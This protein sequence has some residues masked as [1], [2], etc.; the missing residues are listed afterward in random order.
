[1]LGF[2][3]LPG[4]VQ[5]IAR[6]ELTGVIAALRWT[7][8]Y[9]V[10]TVLWC[11]SASTVERLQ[12]L[13][14]GEWQLVGVQA[15]NHDLWQLV[16]EL[17]AELPQDTFQVRWTPSHLD[18]ALCTTTWEEWLAEW[19]GVADSI[20][21]QTNQNR[22]AAFEQLRI[23]V[24][25][26]YNL[27]TQR[28]R[29]L[30][31]FYFAVAELKN[32]Q[33]TVIDLTISDTFDWDELGLHMALT[34][35][36]PITWQT[37]LLQELPQLKYPSEFVVA[38]FEQVFSLDNASDAFAPV[39][40]L[41]ITIWCVLEQGIQIPFWNPDHLQW[42][43]KSYSAAMIKPTLSF[44]VQVFRFVLKRGIRLLGLDQYLLQGIQKPESG[45]Q[46]QSEGVAFCTS[47]HTK[48]CLQDLCQKVAGRRGF[49]KASDLA[50]PI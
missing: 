26:H 4:L 28:I 20:A 24:V 21:V 45:I 13:L 5:S 49:R 11:D 35:A 2:G 34:D 38:L 41:E 19:N 22:S 1:M 47:M 23:N 43:V 40:F 39:T 42:E 14:D 36:M 3:H 46:I 15:E 10:H 32:D 25:E 12:A 18:V 50:R 37:T 27:W 31:R 29:N 30:R 6:S 17:L 16:V 8:K 33:A 7:C 48:Q 44:L 9:K